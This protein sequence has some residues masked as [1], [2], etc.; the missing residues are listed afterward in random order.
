MGVNLGNGPNGLIA[1]VDGNVDHTIES[2]AANIDTASEDEIILLSRVMVKVYG[3]KI[4]D[5]LWMT[6]GYC[7]PQSSLDTVVGDTEI[8]GTLDVS[9]Y[10]RVSLTATGASATLVKAMSSSG[11][12]TG[13]TSRAIT[14]IGNL[15]V[16]NDGLSVLGAVGDGVLTFKRIAAKAD[17]GLASGQSSSGNSVEL[18][19]SN[20]VNGMTKYQDLLSQMQFPEHIY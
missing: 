4:S 10:S 17:G 1:A 14:S 8:K 3:K 13:T 2:Y 12:L 20:S 15:G 11:V 16:T 18:S 5:G 7:G 9:L 6:I 19:L